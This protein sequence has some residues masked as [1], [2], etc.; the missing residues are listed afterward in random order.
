MLGFGSNLNWLSMLLD[1][2][3]TPIL[4]VSG[5]APTNS[6]GASGIVLIDFSRP[7]VLDSKT[8]PI[9]ALAAW[10][11]TYIEGKFRAQRL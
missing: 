10:Q 1:G 11:L 4:A 6:I 9:A 8:N 7:L 2:K 5:A 3:S